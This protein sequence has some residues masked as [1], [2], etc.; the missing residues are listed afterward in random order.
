[1]AF[2][3]LH[4]GQ[5]DLYFWLI[6][7]KTETL[8]LHSLKR[9]EQISVLILTSGRRQSKTLILSMNIDK[10]LK[11]QFLIAICRPTGDKWQSKTLF[12]AI[13][14]LRLSIVKSI[15]DCCLPG[16]ILLMKR[17]FMHRALTMLP[18]SLL[19]DFSCFFVC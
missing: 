4:L 3:N 17:M 16:V 11:E 5:F 18:L 8:F 1:M 14:D 6:S 2:C 12:L 10:N 9:F 13:Y 7:C 19:G 15:F